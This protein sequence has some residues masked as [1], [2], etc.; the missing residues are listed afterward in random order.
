MRGWQGVQSEA[1]QALRRFLLRRL[2]L[3]WWCWNG[4]TLEAC[5]VLTGTSTNE[6]PSPLTESC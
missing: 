3:S 6:R 4:R 1:P 2:V 5:S